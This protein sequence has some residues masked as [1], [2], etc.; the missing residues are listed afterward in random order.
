M[1]AFERLVDALGRRKV[2]FVIIGLSG[3]NYYARSAAS[4]FATQDR[5]L[6]LKPVPDN[7]L[8]AWRACEETGLE[9]YCADEPL[10]RPR[11]RLLAE[12]VVAQKALV[13]ATD[14]AGWTSI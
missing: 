14:G 4:L 6:L 13:R 12:R 8:E 10:D 3:A 2:R 9:L 1:D 11:D 5:D 7:V